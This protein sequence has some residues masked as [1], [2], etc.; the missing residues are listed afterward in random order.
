MRSTA[1]GDNFV[2]DKYQYFLPVRTNSTE[3][4]RPYLVRNYPWRDKYQ[5]LLLRP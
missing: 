3:L 1:F 5:E 2:H 4:S